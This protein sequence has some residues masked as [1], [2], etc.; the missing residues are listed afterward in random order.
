[1][2]IKIAQVVGLNTDQ[3]AAQVVASH[4]GETDFFAVLDLTSDDAFTKGR[5][6]L[7]E[8]SDFF[9]DFESGSI[10][11]KIKATFAEGKSKLGGLE[12]S[13]LLSAISGK[14]L[15]LTFEGKVQAY[16]KRAGKLSSLLPVESPNQLISGFLEEGDRVFLTTHSLTTF[17]GDDLSR[18]LSLPLPILEEEIKDRIG[19]SNLENQGLAALGIDLEKEETPVANLAQSEANSIPE[20]ILLDSPAPNL[21]NKNILKMIKKVL[22]SILGFLWQQKKYFPK[23]GRSRLI[24]AVLLIIVIAS[25][26]GFKIIA[27][28]NAKK[29][30]EFNQIL[31]NAKDDLN[32]A[33]GLSTLNS[34]EAKSK[35]DKAQEKVNLA[36]KLNPKSNEAQDL[37]KQIEQE[38]PHIL[39]QFSVGDF[40]QFLDMDLV[41]KNFRASQISMSGEKILLLDPTI[42][43]LVTVNLTKKSNEIL[44]GSE[45]LGEAALSSLN[46]AFAFVFSKDKGILRV[47]VTNQK[48]IQVTKKD[49]DWGEIKDIYAFSGNVYLLDSG[50]N[51]IWK[52]LP[53]A[54][55]YSDKREYLNKNTKADLTTALRMQIESSLYIL[56]KGGEILRFTR[57]DKDNFSFEG[58]PTPVKDP[59]SFFVSSDT[60]NLYLLDS[61]NSRL[62]IL[63]KTGVYKSQI[64]GDKF[65]SA[66]DLVVDEKGK[67][68]YLLDGS[69]IYSI[70]LK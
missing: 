8:L 29:A 6:I 36:I 34:A 20:E 14:V 11:E 44:A 17:L 21:S 12:F 24:I 23:T 5:Q 66:T 32:S 27:T 28:K 51:Q 25:G 47:D 33:K 18:A 7:S 69:K 56:K 26:V 59:K 62:L 65:A 57:G 3:K 13:L 37:K 39:Q 30:A 64:T 54:D 48:S 9:F 16:L 68:V 41:K 60:D 49:S 19:S 55:N 50:K 61:G 22:G 38:S 70:D 15:Y 53:A 52:Y 31:Q 67:K 1:M 58:L 42:K 63:G 4:R 35:L 2:Q 46:G 43:T 40:P 10:G 45:Q